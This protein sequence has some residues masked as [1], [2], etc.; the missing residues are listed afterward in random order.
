MSNHH[1][2]KRSLA[3]AVAVAAVGLP[4]NADALII[5][6]PSAAEPTP[7]TSTPTVPAATSNSSFQWGDAGIGAAAVVGVLGAGIAS[8]VLVRRRRDPQGLAS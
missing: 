2:I 3:T 1:L 6:G 4:A 8:S 5:E 7:A